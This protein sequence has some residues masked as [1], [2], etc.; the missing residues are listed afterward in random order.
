MKED[1]NMKEKSNMKIV[2]VKP[3]E[4][5]EIIEIEHTLENLQGL[6]GGYIA[7]T[8]PWDDPVGL[9]HNDNGIAEGLQLNRMLMDENGKVYD[10][11]PGTFFIAGLTEDDFGSLSDELAEKYLKRFQYPE[12]FFRTQDDHVFGIRVGSREAPI[13]VF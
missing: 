1:N 8:Y 3:M 5:P 9:I 7:C 6:V 11:V 10:V 12:A 4:P 2:L 13:K